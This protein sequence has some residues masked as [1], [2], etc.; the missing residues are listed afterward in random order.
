MQQREIERKFL[1][2]EKVDKILSRC[3]HRIKISQGYLSKDP[4]RIVRIRH[5]VESYGP[6][7][8]PDGEFSCGV[9]T[10]KT[11]KKEDTAAGV[12][13]FEYKIPAEEAMRLLEDCIQ[14]LIQKTRHIYI[15]FGQYKWEIDVFA[16]HKKGLILAEIELGERLD[17]IPLPN[18]I[19]EEVTGRPEYSNANM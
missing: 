6:I 9:I 3:E 10:I 2:N 12:N 16:G 5:V 1:V 13:E 11:K 14:P 17:Y 7:D 18:W 8:Q 15:Q 19:A 4:E